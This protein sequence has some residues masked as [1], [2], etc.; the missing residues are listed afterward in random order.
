ML[1]RPLCSRPFHIH[2][3]RRLASTFSQSPSP[4]NPG[5]ALPSNLPASGQKANSST[6]KGNVVQVIDPET[7]K[8]VTVNLET[9][10][11]FTHEFGLLPLR[12]RT[13]VEQRHL[14][15]TLRERQNTVYDLEIKETEKKEEIEPDS[16]LVERYITEFIQNR[17]R[18]TDEPPSNEKIKRYIELAKEKAMRKERKKLTGAS[19]KREDQALSFK[20][21]WERR[22]IFGSSMSI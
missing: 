9:V 13:Y 10:E 14:F 8:E 4:T 2:K 19:K 7:K 1:R 11:P 18:K 16:G 21:Q 5:A 22:Q 15:K 17:K 3:L 12:Y 20:D 6:K